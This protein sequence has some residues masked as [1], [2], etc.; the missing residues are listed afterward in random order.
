MNSEVLRIGNYMKKIS[1]WK[2]YSDASGN[3]AKSPKNIM[4]V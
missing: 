1:L 3:H 4:L 2:I